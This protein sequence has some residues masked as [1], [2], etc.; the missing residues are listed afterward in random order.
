MTT[1]RQYVPNPFTSAKEFLIGGP[2]NVVIDFN[3]YRRWTPHHDDYVGFL[4]RLTFEGEDTGFTGLTRNT[5]FNIHT[6]FQFQEITSPTAGGLALKVRTR[7]DSQTS[8]REACFALEEQASKKIHEEFE[9]IVEV[10][11]SGTPQGSIA[12]LARLIFNGP[13]SP[14][15]YGFAG[16]LEEARAGLSQ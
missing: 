9:R 12:N 10:I 4:L 6:E 14:S 11:E 8:W 3:S 13:V 7:R 16:Y 1:L 2:S 5:G 15:E